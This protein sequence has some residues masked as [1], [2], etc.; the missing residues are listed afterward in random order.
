MAR[1]PAQ[2]TLTIYLINK[3]VTDPK[4]ILRPG[5]DH[6]AVS[7]SGSHLGDLYVKVGDLHPPPW[8][9]FFADAALDLA[10]V[11][12]M[13]T[14]A[15]LL[16]PAN[17][18]LFAVTFGFGRLLLQPG[19]TDERFGLKVTLNAVDHTQIRSVDRLTL[20]SPAPHSQIQARIA[21][22]I[23]EFGLNVDQDLLRAVT[24][25]PRDPTLGKRLTGKDAL[26]TTGPFTL[27]DLPA[28]LRRYLAESKKTDYRDHFPWV[29]HIQEV[30]NP[31][32]RDTLD[33]AVV[34]KLR[35]DDLDGM[36]LSIPERIDWQTIEAFAYSPAPSADHHTD[37]HLRAF[38]D[39]I[40]SPATLT[41]DG[42]KHRRVYA[43]SSEAGD[44]T[45]EW[46]VYQCLYAELALSGQ[47]YL[48]NSGTWYNVDATFRDR[49]EKSFQRVPRRRATLP[50]AQGSEAERAYNKR[51]AD[52]TPGTYALMDRKNI[53]YPDPKS[54]IEFCDLFTIQQELIHVKHYAASS[55]LS[56]L[57]AQG[58]VSG[59]L[60]AQDPGFRKA[61]NK[62]LPATHQLANP[63][64][65]LTPETYTVTYAIISASTR[66]L[67]IPFFSKVTLSHAAKTLRGLGY[68]AQ[69][70]KISVTP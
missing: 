63:A 37:I 1:G 15:V 67:T 22:S 14:S 53:P 41:I 4:L 49:I 55:T 47:Q 70:A 54:P 52:A 34:Q 62:K 33:E 60:F 40:N 20:D 51:V 46:P 35:Q 36:W 31:T 38:L 27:A 57:F 45:L 64:Q 26:R 28:L 59:T 43:I 39:A 30:K 3:G 29:D 9:T 25:N 68:T 23:A 2:R 19:T 69:L 8:V 16:V 61:V 18:R 13:S 5:T 12:G 11:Q 48:L 42:L 66:L 56:H 44:I 21:A 58:L 24:G 10:S 6:Q 17:H 7:V 50:N 65:L 32:L